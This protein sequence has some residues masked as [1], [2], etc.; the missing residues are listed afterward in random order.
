MSVH[1]YDCSGAPIAYTN[2]GIHIYRFNGEPVAYFYGPSVYGFSGRHLGWFENGLIRDRRGNTIFFAQGGTGGPMKP[3]TQIA[4]IKRI[5]QIKPIK[6]TRAMRP[7]RPMKTLSW[8]QLSADTF[9][10]G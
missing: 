8:S 9:F 1:F 7:M 6:R 4:P 3:I 5:R 10:A 2:D